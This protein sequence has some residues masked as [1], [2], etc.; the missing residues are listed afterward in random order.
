MSVFPSESPDWVETAEWAGSRH[1]S[2]CL[3]G[4]GCPWSTQALATGEGPLSQVCLHMELSR[5]R[6]GHSGA[7]TLHFQR[8][9]AGLL[10]TVH[11]A[12]AP[13][14]GTDGRTR[15][16]ARLWAP[17]PLCLPVDVLTLFPPGDVVKARNPGHGDDP[18][19]VASPGP[20]ARHRL[21]FQT[22]RAGQACPPVPGVPGSPRRPHLRAS[23]TGGGPGRGVGAGASGTSVPLYLQLE[24]EE[25]RQK[26]NRKAK[27]LRE[28]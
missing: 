5:P 22:P 24:M 21:I 4:D 1:R 20:N 14:S 28:S 9:A 7:P 27:Q 23:A 3:G 18:A 6:G 16:A 17:S 10:R 25:N 12:G 8:E 19:A 11:L 15:A 2:G 26:T 13:G